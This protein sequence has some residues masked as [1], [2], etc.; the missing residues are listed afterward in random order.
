MHPNPSDILPADRPPNTGLRLTLLMFALLAM[1]MLWAM[2]YLVEQWAYRKEKGAQVALRES[3]AEIGEVKLEAINELFV[4]V[5]KR[6]NPSVV[7]IDTERSSFRRADEQAS[8]Y[9]QRGQQT[10]GEASGVIVDPAASLS[11]IITSSAKP[12]RS[13]FILAATLVSTSPASL[14]AIRKTI[15]P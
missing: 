5:A 3:L 7:H 9:G 1:A 8:L 10:R 11:R 4:S 2:P 13:S 6:L 15:W 14:A 12:R